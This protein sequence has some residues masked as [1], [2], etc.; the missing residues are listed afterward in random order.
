[1]V[2]RSYRE[3]TWLKACLVGLLPNLGLFLLV[4]GFLVVSGYEVSQVSP[5]V[6]Y[7]V[8]GPLL[9]T[10][11]ENL[12]SPDLTDFPGEEII[13]RAAPEDTINQVFLE[14]N[15]TKMSLSLPGTI[16]ESRVLMSDPEVIRTRAVESFFNDMFTQFLYLRWV[17]YSE[18]KYRDSRIYIAKESAAAPKCGRAQSWVGVRDK[19][20]RVAVLIENR[21]CTPNNGQPNY[22]TLQFFLSDVQDF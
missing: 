12:G 4:G 11:S 16:Y 7:V 2:K 6:D 13:R 19:R 5:M 9:S 18:T 20:Y 3:W 14:I 17:G 22:T 8:P 1:M 21:S 15:E 10:K